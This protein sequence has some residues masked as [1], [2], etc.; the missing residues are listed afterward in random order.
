[1]RY[2]A[3][4]FGCQFWISVMGRHAAIDT[5]ASPAAHAPAGV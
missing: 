4:A 1:L 5:T 3:A 2:R